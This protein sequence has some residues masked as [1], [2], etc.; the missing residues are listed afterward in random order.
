MHA[1]RLRPQMGSTVS[2]ESGQ[3][4]VATNGSR[5]AADTESPTEYRDS[6]FALNESSTEERLHELRESIR[7]W[8]W[9]TAPPDSSTDPV[10]TRQGPVDAH[11]ES[12]DVRPRPAVLRPDP[13]AA[14]V[15]VRLEPVEA[16]PS[17]A[18]LRPDPIPDP[19]LVPPESVEDRPPPVAVRPESV[20]V[21][22]PAPAL[23]E[24]PATSR[25]RHVKRSVESDRLDQPLAEAP[26]ANGPTYISV[27]PDTAENPC[28][29]SHANRAWTSP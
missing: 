22:G 6:P 26:P 4:D 21:I 14:A 29:G 8:N 9:R 1:V 19:V 20:V 27:E 16:R 28:A 23:T 24:E 12:V 10:D 15:R 25:G 3:V 18:D 7:A 13:V 2:D 17:P 5:K 11:P